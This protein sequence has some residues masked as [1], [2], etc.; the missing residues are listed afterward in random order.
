MVTILHCP[1]AFAAPCPQAREPSIENRLAIRKYTEEQELKRRG[2]APLRIELRT[3]SN[4]FQR[5]GNHPDRKQGEIS[6]PKEPAESEK[7][8]AK[9]MT[10]NKIPFL[11]AGEE[12]TIYRFKDGRSEVHTIDHQGREYLSRFGRNNSFQGSTWLNKKEFQHV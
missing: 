11:P 5:Q 2:K 8:P 10:R 7:P 3:K 9:A 1:P 12:V 4:S 6:A